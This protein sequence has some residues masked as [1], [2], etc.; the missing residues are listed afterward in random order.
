MLKYPKELKTKIFRIINQQSNA[1]NAKDAGWDIGI[2]EFL[3]N[4]WDLKALPI[5]S[6]DDRWS[7]AYDDAVQHLVKNDDWSYEETFI[8]YFKLLT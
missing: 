2:I 1:F 7:N 8:D 3:N 6:G 5:V 4:I